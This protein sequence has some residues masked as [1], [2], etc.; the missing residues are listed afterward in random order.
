MSE[1]RT[2]IEKKYKE[3]I[4]EY[5]FSQIMNIRGVNKYAVVKELPIYKNWSTTLV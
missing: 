5:Y 3:R 4:N 1:E 2:P